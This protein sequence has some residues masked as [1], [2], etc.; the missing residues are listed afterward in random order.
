MVYNLVIV[1]YCILYIVDVHK[2]IFVRFV[3]NLY[4]F[5]KVGT[6]FTKLYKFAHEFVHLYIKQSLFAI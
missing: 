5:A 1:Q 6:A 3:S 4:K 2:T